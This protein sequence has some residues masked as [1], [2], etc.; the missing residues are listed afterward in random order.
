MTKFEVLHFSFDEIE[1]IIK[2][3]GFEDFEIRFDMG[4]FG[5]WGNDEETTDNIYEAFEK[6]IEDNYGMKDFCY[7]TSDGDQEDFDALIVPKSKKHKYAIYS[8]DEND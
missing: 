7:L 1:E 8:Y 2:S 3:L 4:C 6:Y 5:I